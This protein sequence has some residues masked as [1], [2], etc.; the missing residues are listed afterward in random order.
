MAHIIAEVI[1]VI[2]SDDEYVSDEDVDTTEIEEGDVR[3]FEEADGDDQSANNASVILL[4]SSFDDQTTDEKLQQKDGR[5]VFHRRLNL[6]H[7]IF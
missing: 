1:P 4:D 7:M 2:S 6:N 3:N 5:I